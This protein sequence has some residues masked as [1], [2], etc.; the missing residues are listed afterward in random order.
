MG[1]RTCFWK[2]QRSRPPHPKR[3]GSGSFGKGR[4]MVIPTC[5]V[6]PT[7]VLFP[8]W[9]K[10]RKK[11]FSQQL[12]M[13][14]PFA[15]CIAAPLQS[16]AN[17]PHPQI[18]MHG[19]MQKSKS[20]WKVLRRCKASWRTRAFICFVAG[21]TKAMLLIFILFCA[22]TK[23]FLQSRNHVNSF[24]NHVS[25]EC[26]GLSLPSQFSAAVDKMCGSD[27]TNDRG[28]K[29][30]AMPVISFSCGVPI[31]WHSKQASIVA[32]SSSEAEHIAL[33]GLAKESILVVQILIFIGIPVKTPITIC[34]GS[35]GAT[36]VAE[37][38]TS[39]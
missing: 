2:K 8:Q 11:G 32:L 27:W 23:K 18:V 1:M 9:R 20:F 37:N 7:I 38:V 22:E 31:V 29:K 14:H 26:N 24:L 15:W 6:S 12:V 36:F 39:N 28:N 17:R 21:L 34:V 16:L 13:L 19:R 3:T 5:P 30:S 4:E 10:C 35:T 25:C 33:S